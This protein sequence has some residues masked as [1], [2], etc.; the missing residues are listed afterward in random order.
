M[1]YWSP[2][3]SRPITWTARARDGRQETGLHGQVEAEFRSG[4]VATLRL[5]GPTV[6]QYS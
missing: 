4:Q 1:S 2:G 6:S 3:R 5:G